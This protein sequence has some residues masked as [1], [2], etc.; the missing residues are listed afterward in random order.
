MLHGSQ[1]YVK[2]IIKDFTNVPS[3]VSPNTKIIFLQADENN[4]TLIKWN[5]TPSW[6]DL[7]SLITED[8]HIDDSAF[9][10]QDALINSQRIIDVVN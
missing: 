8:G 3:I 1:T 10:K 4:I 5:N 6:F 2:D 7:Y 9:N